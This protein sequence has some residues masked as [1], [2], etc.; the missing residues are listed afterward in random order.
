MIAPLVT[1]EEIVDITI[2]Q[3]AH[4]HPTLYASQIDTKALRREAAEAGFAAQHNGKEATINAIE[5][6]FIKYEEGPQS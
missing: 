3:R 1:W 4:K 2:S 5:R 6:V